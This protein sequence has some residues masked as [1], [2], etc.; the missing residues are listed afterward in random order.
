M[1][2]AMGLTGA[3]LSHQEGRK[4][5]RLEIFDTTRDQLEGWNSQFGGKIESFSALDLEDLSLA[6]QSQAAPLIIRDRLVISQSAEKAD[7]KKLREKYP[8]RK[9]LIY[10]PGLAFGTGDHP[11]T[12]TC[13][14]LVTDFAVQ[15]QRADQQSWNFLDLGC[16][17]GI[18]CAA[19]AALGANKI[20]GLDFD[21]T[22]IRTAHKL[23]LQNDLDQACLLEADVL[24]WKPPGGLR[25]D[26]IAANIFHDVLVELFP[27][28]PNWLKPGGK[29]IVSGILRDQEKACLAVGNKAGFTFHGI[30]R[31]GKWITARGELSS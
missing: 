25:F 19:A 28:L 9:I 21:G 23:A 20:Q 18:L 11:T 8:E 5:W 16:G 14:R 13:L 7:L 6:H 15:W 30:L 3:T 24:E 2:E 29:L 12:A 31:R 1:I 10:P 27:R 26:F 4:T 22:A 17:S